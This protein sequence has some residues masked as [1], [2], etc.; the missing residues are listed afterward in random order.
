MCGIAGLI[1]FSG[2]RP[3][4]LGLGEIMAGTLRHRGPDE[5]GGYDDA[6]VSLGHARLSIIDLDAGHQPMTNEEGTV[7]V[8]FNG[9]IYN[10]RSLADDLRA[11]GHKFRTHSDTEVIVHLY[12]EFGD[13]FVHRLN[14]MF[15]IGLWDVT[16]RRLLL[17]RDR[18]GIK[19][20][21]WHDDGTRI[22]FG[23]ELKAVLA[24]Q[25]RE[26]RVD[27]QALTDYLTFGHV[28]APRTMFKD[29]RKLEP[30]HLAVCT[31]SG[32]ALRPYWDI[33]LVIDDGATAS[34]CGDRGEA[35]WIDEFTGLFEDAVASRLVADVP[36]G[37][38]LS[39]GIDSGA[40]VKAMCRTSKGAVLTHTVGFD[41]ADHDER[42][43][44]RQTADLLATDHRE[45][46]VR[47]DAA[48]T[49]E[50]LAARFDEPFA[51]PSAVPTYYLSRAT[52]ERVTVALA[53]DGG[54]ELLG[55]YRRYRFD[56][57][58][59]AIRARCPAS[60]RRT[61][62]WIGSAYP[63]ADWLPRP[64]RARVTLQNLACDAATAHLRSTSLQA[65]T[66]PGRLL[67]RET[68][69]ELSSYDPFAH[70][71]ALFAR[72][73]G[74]GL[75]QRLLYLDMKTLMVD[76]ILTKVDRASMAVGLEVRV[77]LLDY[78][79]VELVAR[80]PTALRVGKRALRQ[81]VAR[82]LGPAF[83][84][85]P[86]KGFDVPVDA[87]FKGPLRMMA[88]DLLLSSSARCAEW[89][90]RQAMRRLFRQ[91]QSGLLMGGSALWALLSLELWAR[92]CRS[93]G[94]NARHRSVPYHE[95]AGRRQRRPAIVC[96][97]GGPA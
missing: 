20:L 32:T 23:S 82:W 41:E 91:H 96:A 69:S 26:P 5:L 77:P 59:A 44:A 65:G 53:G 87:W 62:G 50:H 36:L 21:Y 46:M 86:K 22:L 60:L 37:A 54:D 25:E 75:L 14:G 4:E 18:L 83:A 92:T 74:C 80:M 29:L 78:R 13:E 39:G 1:R 95:L 89:I 70:G 49:A 84:D 68:R 12:E 61:A 9:E 15:A 35:E 27:V 10:Y 81:V 43:A 48:W 52:R 94:Q 97:A 63:K 51:D 28:P 73:A 2:L 11:R 45:V 76:G 71:R 72:G 19:P 88:G 67:N 64:L 90:D 16:R 58:E 85:R 66:L 57:A 93:A 17:V 24:A 33:P 40:V 38:F 31:A 7:W 34:G 6:W 3:S 30:G 47:P 8:V 56:L 55:G 42:N 79:L